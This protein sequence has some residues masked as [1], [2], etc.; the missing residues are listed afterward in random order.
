MKAT[1]ASQKIFSEIGGYRPDTNI[2]INDVLFS[3]QTVYITHRCLYSVL[4]C[5]VF[6]HTV[7]C[8][9]EAQ[10]HTTNNAVL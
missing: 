1:K 6:R 4:C 8:Q 10:E 7:R 3:Q 5:T 2:F 9:R